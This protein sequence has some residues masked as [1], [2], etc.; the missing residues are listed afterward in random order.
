MCRK[1]H[2]AQDRVGGFSWES[3]LFVSVSRLSLCRGERII[4]LRAKRYHTFLGT[5]E[6][7][8]S[9]NVSKNE[10]GAT[11]SDSFV[12]AAIWEECSRSFTLKCG[13][14]LSLYPM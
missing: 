4:I 5:R 14:L 12:S 13:G 6:D 10:G 8:I 9:L 1:E 2:V 3:A 11:T 7:R